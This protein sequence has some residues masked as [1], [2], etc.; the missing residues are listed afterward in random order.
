MT[1][2]AWSIPTL[3]SS[4]PGLTIT[5]Q[6][7]GH[8]GTGGP[9]T[10]KYGAV[11]SP[12]PAR[13]CLVSAAARSAALS[14]SSMSSR[15][16]SPA[17][18]APSTSSPW[19]VIAVSR[20]LKSCA[21]PPASRPMASIFCAS[22]SCSCARRSSV[23]SSAIPTVRTTLPDASRTGD[24]R[25]RTQRTDPS[26]RT[27]RKSSLPGS[28]PLTVARISANRRSRSSGWTASSQWLRSA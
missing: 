7:R 26:G 23:T 9:S 4:L 18:S 11:G 13:S 27:T 10:A 6:G 3:A 22:T 20:L 16:G 24:T 14:I 21:T 1:T 28:A 12:A 25:L 2:L 17:R 15:N 8:F 5:G 19:P